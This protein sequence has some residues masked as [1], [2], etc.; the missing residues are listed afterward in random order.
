MDILMTS[1]SHDSSQQK[2]SAEDSHR[3][4]VFADM[5]GF[6]ALTEA[7][8]IDP[9]MLEAYSRL[10]QSWEALDEIISHRNPLTQVFS[11]FHICLAGAIKLA[12]MAHPVTAITFSDSVFFAT[13]YL[14]EAT[15]F[16]VGLTQSLLSAKIPVRMG[17]AS[18]SFVAL[19][20]R[21]DVSSS[22]GDHA[23]QFLG[24]AVVRAHQTEKC[25]IKGIRILLHPSIEP[26][27]KD[28]A[29]CPKLP[30]VKT[31]PVSPLRCS[32]REFPN[33]SDVR[34]ELNYWDTAPT[35][36]RKAWH[37]LQDMWAAA[38]DSAKEHYPATAEAINRMRIALG[39]P[40][41]QDLRRRTLP[42]SAHQ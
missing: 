41:L 36:E 14:Y 22:S 40:P 9:R 32:E 6:A 10:P 34:Y 5:L 33:K 13:R 3:V 29:H 37:A 17:I 31:V 2:S 20:F 15:T 7:H 30:P 19:K 18:G 25:G 24:T 42:R 1:I 4:V 35:K 27:L 11:H 28:R 16:A 23:S 38:P 8:P 39:Q 21:S 12:E 26:L